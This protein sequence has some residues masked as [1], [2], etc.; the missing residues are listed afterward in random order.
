MAGDALVSRQ[1]FCRVLAALLC[2]LP[3]V[4]QSAGSSAPTPY[5]LASDNPNRIGIHAH[6]SGVHLQP[7]TGTFALR[8]CTVAS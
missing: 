2:V 1:A 3:G 6:K 7:K 5:T 8:S 4:E